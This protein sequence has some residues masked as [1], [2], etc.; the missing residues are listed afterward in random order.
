MRHSVPLSCS[1]MLSPGVPSLT[2]APTP[3][4]GRGLG[5]W[6]CR[7]PSFVLLSLCTPVLGECFAVRRPP[8]GC[9]PHVVGVGLECV[10]RFVGVAGA[11]RGVDAHGEIG[12]AHV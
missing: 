11:R 12:R 6:W 9:L 3:P 1:A 8:L 2:P 4:R 5:R 10:K 7:A